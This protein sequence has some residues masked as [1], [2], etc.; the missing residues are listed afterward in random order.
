MKRSK[1]QY[2]LVFAL[3]IF[4][5]FSCKKVDETQPNINILSPLEN[6]QF[7]VFDTVTILFEA[8]DE[9][10]LISVDVQIVNDKFVPVTNSVS[11]SVS[12]TDYSGG[13]EIIL[14][15]KLLETGI[16]YALVT[17]ND[18][19]NEQRVF[20][21]IR[22]A[23][24]PK[25][26]RAI[27]FSDVKN[28]GIS[29]ILK[30]DSLFQST[31]LFI[32]PNRDILKLCVNSAKDQLTFIGHFSNGISTYNLNNRLELWSDAVFG[33]LQ[34]PSYMDLFCN[35]SQIYTTI[36]EREIRSY[37]FKGALTMNL[38]T[39]E[40][41]PKTIYADDKYLIVMQNP[42]GASTHFLY[43][44]HAQ[45]RAF[46]WQLQIPMD[47]VSICKLDEDQLLLFGNDNNMARVLQYH[48]SA[49]GYW[50]P[51]QLPEGKLLTATKLDGQNYAIAHQNG[52][53]FY[54]YN[55]NFL[56]QIRPFVY[57]DICF[58]MARNVL[59]AARSNTLEEMTVSG[60][61]LN[62]ILHSDSIASIDVHYTR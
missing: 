7:T 6:T 4:L 13:A 29:A 53:Y 9:T 18:G 55:P 52:L 32:N 16:Y 47:V 21:K 39:E 54:T 41:R 57:Q 12:G 45:T 38:P 61:V 1:I 23:A 24:I 27:Y 51:R 17:A 48:I 19:V 60:Q 11:V 22:I 40:K 42:V 30:I 43:V 35:K 31:S 44:Y 14:S 62:T 46:L 20:Q 25:L 34:A 50:E 8:T 2:S 5:A 36:Y 58:D 33:P 56:N 10:Q 28:S 26:R 59:V 15:N 3:L 37:T 49:N